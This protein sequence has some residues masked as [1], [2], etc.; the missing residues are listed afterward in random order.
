ML[1]AG[2]DTT[3]I[4]KQILKVIDAP[5]KKRF[6]PIREYA[7]RSSRS[8]VMAISAA[9][10]RCFFIPYNPRPESH[11]S[12]ASDTLSFLFW[13]SFPRKACPVSTVASGTAEASFLSKPDSPLPS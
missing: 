2:E 9:V 1:D 5:T 10:R 7:I 4:E 8:S 13:Q 3:A 6:S 11:L 12:M